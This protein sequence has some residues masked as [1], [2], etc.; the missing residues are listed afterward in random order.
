MAVNAH[1]VGSARPE[2]IRSRP[3]PRKTFVNA[4]NARLASV[5][6]SHATPTCSLATPTCSLATPTC[7]LATPTCS[8]ATPTCSLATPTCSLATPTCSLATPTCSLA[9]LTCSL[10][11]LTCSLATAGCSEAMAACGRAM[12]A[13]GRA[14]ASYSRTVTACTHTT[15]TCSQTMARCNRSMTAGSGAA[16]R[17]KESYGCPRTKSVSVPGAVATGSRGSFGTNKPP[18]PVATAPGADTLHLR[19]WLQSHNHACSG[20]DDSRGQS[21]W[22]PVTCQ[23]FILPSEKSADESAHSIFLDQDSFSGLM[24]SRLANESR[25]QEN[26]YGYPRH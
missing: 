1:P 6:C 15:V 22:S 7:S 17:Q 26:Q 20:A 2:I 25:N 14:M 19:R 5:A 23:R 16:L 11:T 13:C 8:L 9:T 18:D 24:S 3:G 4:D 12:A 10:A 21:I